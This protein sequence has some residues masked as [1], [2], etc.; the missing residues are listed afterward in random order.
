MVPGAGRV[1]VTDIMFPCGSLAL[2]EPVYS[3]LLLSA[4]FNEQ[5]AA[6]TVAYV[7]DC[8]QVEAAVRRQMM[9][10]IMF[11]VL[12]A[13]T[14]AILVHMWCACIACNTI[15]ASLQARPHSNTSACT[16]LYIASANPL[17]V[18]CCSTTLLIDLIW[19]LLQALPE[20]EKVRILEVGSGSGGTSAVVMAA[21]ADFGDRVDFVYTDLSPQLVAYG[22]KTYSA[23][24][25]FA[26]FHVL[27]IERDLASQVGPQAN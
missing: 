14:P 13:L 2:V 18:A 22:R 5:L 19:H 15:R 9:P 16:L 7:R 20:A 25:E 8:L 11:T 27:D 12:A 17:D 24:Y 26:R 1:R 21:L 23:K 10:P 4:P 3:S 6:A